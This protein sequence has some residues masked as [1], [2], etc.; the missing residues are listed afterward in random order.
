[1]VAVQFFFMDS[2]LLCFRGLDK[3]SF[4]E[5][6]LPG[7]ARVR[8]TTGEQLKLYLIWTVLFLPVSVFGSVIHGDSLAYVFCCN[9][10]GY[11]VPW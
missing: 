7:A 4:V 2:A 10:A 1:M 9:C 6:A 3:A 5:K 11:A 8:K